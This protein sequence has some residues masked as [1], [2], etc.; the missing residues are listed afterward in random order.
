MT[1]DALMNQCR[2]P[3]I[4]EQ[5]ERSKNDQR[6]EGVEIRSNL[7]FRRSSADGRRTDHGERF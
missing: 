2:E 4:D 1:H 7:R 6:L 5:I 3:R